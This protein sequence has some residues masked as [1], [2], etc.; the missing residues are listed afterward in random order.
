MILKIESKKKKITMDYV[1]EL[2]KYASKRGLTFMYSRG[3]TYS[4]MIGC[5][6]MTGGPTFI[7]CVQVGYYYFFSNA[8]Y[9]WQD[10]CQSAAQRAFFELNKET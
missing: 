8:M 4:Q 10:A 6:D 5:I 2:A 7:A 3:K 1:V 9:S